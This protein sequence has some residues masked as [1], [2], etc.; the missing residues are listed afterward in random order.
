MF[1]YKGELFVQEEVNY[2]LFLHKK[3][4]LFLHNFMEIRFSFLYFFEDK[5]FGVLIS[6]KILSFVEN[7]PSKSVEI[8]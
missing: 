4:N 2:F 1:N 8:Y 6:L 5:T 3:K 7:F